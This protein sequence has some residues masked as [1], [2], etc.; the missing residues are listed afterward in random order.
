MTH[1]RFKVYKD[2]SRINI[3]DNGKSIG[4]IYHVCALLNR[5]SEENEYYKAKCGSLEEGYLK[6]QRENRELK[7]QNKMLQEKKQHLKEKIKYLQKLRMAI[8]DITIKEAID[9]IEEMWE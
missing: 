4:N 9:K 2:N 8:R 5:I 3:N 7:Y 1:I 6:L